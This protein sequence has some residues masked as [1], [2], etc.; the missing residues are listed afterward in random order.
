[1][2]SSGI[3]TALVTGANRGL[4]FVEELVD[5][6]TDRVFAAARNVADCVPLVQRFG[7]T[8]Q[9]IPLDLADPASIDAAVALTADI[10]LLV[11]NAGISLIGP[12]FDHA[13]ADL[14]AMFEVNFWGPQR[15]VRG[16]VPQLR[17]N[18]GGILHVLSMASLL[19]ALSAEGYS[20]SK[21]AAMMAG[22]G[23]RH[24]LRA[25]GISVTLCYP[26]F[27][28]TDLGRAFDVPRA[29][30]RLIAARALDDWQ[31]G[32]T[33][34]FSDLFS[35]MTRDALCQQMD[36]VL[37]DPGKLLEEMV[38]IFVNDPDAGR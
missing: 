6:G 26:G 8:I 7:A 10:D 3:E 35:G 31:S 30:A 4:A 20:A 24:A 12:F 28:E 37:T 36:R 11:S 38:G 1:M 34:S 15:L 23:M 18:G 13:E 27:I 25:D 22:H 17:K 14:R 19:P 33:S 29:P 32:K 9:P 2:S 5:R 21:A 16:L